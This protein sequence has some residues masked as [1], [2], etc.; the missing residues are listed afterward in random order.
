MK[1]IGLAGGSGSGKGTVGQILDSLGIPTVDTDAIYHEMTSA[2]S[3]CLKALADE[4]GSEVISYSGAL[5]RAALAKL[6]FVGEGAAERRS[7]LNEIAHRFILEEARAR[8]RDLDSLGYAFAAV[9][10]P[11]LFESGFDSECDLIITVVAPMPERIARI[12]ARDGITEEAASARIESQISDDELISHSDYVIY[13]NGD[14][15]TLR[16]AVI[17]TVN[18]IKVEI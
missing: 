18:K 6:V 5:N 13:N 2:E 3:P 16:E 8:L 4:F 11:L 12:V 9:D 10:A 15:D 1:T 7:R 17:S 14:M